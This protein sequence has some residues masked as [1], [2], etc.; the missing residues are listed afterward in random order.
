MKKLLAFLCSVCPFCIA[1]R[2]YPD[3][4]FAKKLAKAEEN[5]PA[6]NAYKEIHNKKDSS[7]S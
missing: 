5:C 2:K 6:C 7:N 4:A 3:S 1:A